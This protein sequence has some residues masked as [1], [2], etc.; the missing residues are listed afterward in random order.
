MLE[1][2]APQ[3]WHEANEEI[4]V[5]RKRRLDEDVVYGREMVISKAKGII[6]DATYCTRLYSPE[7]IKAML[8]SAGFALVTIQKDFVSHAEKGDYGLM[9]NRMIVIAGKE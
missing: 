9:T 1:N 5:C 8:T 7:K 3:S 6:R 2:F 4:V